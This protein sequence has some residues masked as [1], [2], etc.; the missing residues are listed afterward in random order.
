MSI[1]LLAA[2]GLM[3]RTLDRLNNTDLGFTPER[4]L[5]AQVAPRTNPEAFFASLVER[6]Q[7]LPGVI[8][9]GATSGAPM[10]S[11]N[12]SLNVYPVGTVADRVNDVGSIGLAF[13]QRW[14]LRGDADRHARRAR[15]HPA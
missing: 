4:I 13:H 1:V 9:A 2:S 14:L 15:F 5:T 7:Q 10:T 8:G 3:L 12:T 6:V 11:G